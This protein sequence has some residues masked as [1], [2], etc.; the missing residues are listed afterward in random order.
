MADPDK[1]V[2][3]AACEAPAATRRGRE[4]PGGFRRVLLGNLVDLLQCPSCGALWCFGLHG[5]PGDPGIGIRW[6]YGARDWQRA[7]DVDDGVSLARWYR[8]QVRELTGSGSGEHKR[9]PSAV[10]ADGVCGP[11]AAAQR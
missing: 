5:S 9:K 7:Y 10:M 11:Q 4:V 3:C 8:R 2:R 1:T 6:T